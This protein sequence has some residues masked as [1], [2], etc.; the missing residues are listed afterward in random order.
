MAYQDSKLKNRIINENGRMFVTFDIPS[1]RPHLIILLKNDNECGQVEDFIADE[2]VLANIMDLARKN[3]LAHTLSLHTGYWYKAKNFHI[4]LVLN[5]EDYVNLFNAACITMCESDKTREW[6][7]TKE[8]LNNSYI[9]NVRI[10]SKKQFDK[11][12]N[13]KKDDLNEI[14]RFKMSPQANNPMPQWNNSNFKLVY[15]PNEPKIGFKST[16]NDPNPIEAFK[17]MVAFSRFHGY[18][19]KN[20]G[21][22]ICLFLSDSESHI[23]G[24]DKHVLGYVLTTGIEYYKLLGSAG[25]SWKNSFFKNQ[26]FNVLT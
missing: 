1:P 18:F 26:N 15:H 19:D 4:H 8:P 5:T 24:F 23:N 11:C 14:Q 6:K 7:I 17:A 22:H 3:P 10:Y 21:A 16:V 13:Y 2:N 25:E 20:K 9:E 12:N